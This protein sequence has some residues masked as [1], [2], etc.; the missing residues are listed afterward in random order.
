M[1]IYRAQQ[2]S[3]SAVVGMAAMNYINRREAGGTTN[4]K[5]FN[6]RQTG[7]TMAKYSGWLLEIMQYIWRTHKLPEIKNEERDKE[8]QGKSRH[9][10]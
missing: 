3:R 9:T 5:P 6:S 8:V 1:V 2:S 4:E 10:S 7:K